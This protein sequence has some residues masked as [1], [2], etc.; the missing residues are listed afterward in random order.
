MASLCFRLRP[1][2]SRYTDYG[3]VTDDGDKAVRSVR[4]R[5]ETRSVRLRLP[6][7][8]DPYWQSLERD[9]AA[10]YHRPL[11]GGAGRWWGRVRQGGKYKIEALAT[12]DDHDQADGIAI[13]NWAQAQAAV[14]AWAGR[15]TAAGPYTVAD[16]CRDYTNDLSARRGAAAAREADGRLRLYLLPRLG[17]R[18][19]AD[20]I[21]ADLIGWRNA[22][23]GNGDDEEAIRRSRDTANRVRAIAWAAFNLAFK[24]R[25][26]ADDQAWRRVG[27]FK[28][29]GV[30]RKIILTDVQQQN[31]IDACEPG[32]RELIL[33]G[34]WTGARL[35]ELTAARVRDLDPGAAT[36]AVNGKTGARE[37]HLPVDALA[38]LRRL[39]SGKRPDERLLTTGGRP[40]TKSMHQHP[41][42]AAVRKA[43]LDPAVTFYTLRHSYISRALKAGVPVKA[44]ADQ[45][46]TSI[47]MIEKHYAKFIRGDL[48][49]YAEKAAP[50][51]R[52]DAQQTVVA[53]RP[54]AA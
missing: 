24:A 15:Q 39:A 7:R 8:K 48:A 45:C 18:R 25:R 40:W 12:A 6:G 46:G 19:L 41:F 31:L 16:A 11:Q 3:R 43:G 38:L 14:R 22:M 28:G 13:L 33:L 27:P 50:K 21:E 49:E 37:I 42:A 34:A 26:V 47:A 2:M 10:G 29:V 4:T 54:G 53:I 1:Y 5:I 32:L 23:V 17:E 52:V 9:L 36:L 20:L 30:A 44:V 51:L 35:G